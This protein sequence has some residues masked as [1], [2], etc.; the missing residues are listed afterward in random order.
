[1]IALGYGRH[2]APHLID[3]ITPVNEVADHANSDLKE[4]RID[5]FHVLHCA[6]SLKPLLLIYVTLADHSRR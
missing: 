6:S 4:P 1:M 3:V 2:S 5:I